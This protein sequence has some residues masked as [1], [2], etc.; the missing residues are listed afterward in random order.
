MEI[1]ELEE[2]E[3]DSFLTTDEFEK[4]IDLNLLA[5]DKEAENGETDLDIEADDEENA[6]D[7]D[8]DESDDYEGRS[9]WR[10]WWCIRGRGWGIMDVNNFE[11]LK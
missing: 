9:I 10:F 2:S 1:R 7:D 3:K 8:F 4:S 11:G 6:F 5:S